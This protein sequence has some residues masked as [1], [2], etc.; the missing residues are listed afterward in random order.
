[1]TANGYLQ[2]GLYLVLLAAVAKPLG[3]YM[4]NV[5]EG[6]PCGLDRLLG[7]CER[8]TYRLAGVN[9]TQEMTW[10]RYAVALMWFSCFGLL[11]LYG[12]QR[13][14]DKLP[15]NPQ[16]MA[17]TTPDLSFNTSGSF[18]SSTNWQS[19]GGE[20]TLSYLTQMLGLTVQNFVSA[21][22]GIAVL[23]ALIRGLARRSAQTI[24][25]FW[26]DL[27]RST[28]YILLPM[29]AVLALALVSQGV[30]QNL[31][32]YDTVSLVQPA[33][34]ADGNDVTEQQIAQG[35]AASQIAIKQLGTNG[36]GFFNVNSAH[37]FEN[38]TPLSNFLEMFAILVIPA[39]LCYTF[40]VM[41]GDTRQGWAVLAAMYVI[42]IPLLVLCVWSE[43]SGNP[44]FDRMESTRSPATSIPAATWKARKSATESPTRACGRLRPPRPQ[45]ARSTQCTTPTRR[46]AAWCRCGSCSLARLSSA[47]SVAVFMACS[48]TPLLPSSSPG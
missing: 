48:F 13:L 34:D 3:K 47:A 40:G 41:V 10:R 20:T 11:A 37:P 43:Q 46:W 8:L 28:L 42:F 23:A 27:T 14:Q 31:K 24:G 6:K 7:W 4:A 36:G 5:L 30:I 39:A 2:L 29:S 1:M 33:K 25:N 18:V 32:A 9:P 12:I 45:T 19:Y 38:P 16:N 22:T 15:L 35:P 17:A 21:A 26:V 44:A